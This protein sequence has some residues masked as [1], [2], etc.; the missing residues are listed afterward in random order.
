VEL[1]VEVG[2]AIRDDGCG[3]GEEGVFVVFGVDRNDT[4]LAIHAEDCGAGWIDGEGWG[5]IGLLEGRRN[6]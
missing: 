2:A 3:A 1:C 5:H 6:S 4:G